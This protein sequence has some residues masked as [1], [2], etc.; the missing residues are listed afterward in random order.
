MHQDIAL[1]NL[2]VNPWTDNI[3]LFDFDFIGR[4]R[5]IGYFSE[6]DD[7]KG[8]IFTMYEIIT[9]NIHF[10]SVPYDQQNP[11]EVQRLEEWPQHPDV[12]LDRPVSDYRSVLNEWVSRRENGRRIS[13]YT[14]AQEPIDWPQL[15]DPP[16][17][18][19]SLVLKVTPLP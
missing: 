14:E 11:A 16:K 2:L 1:R 12:R 15:G 13:V 3:L 4:I 9:L 18:H 19:S 8:V 5:D 17:R 6:R 7:V 10:S